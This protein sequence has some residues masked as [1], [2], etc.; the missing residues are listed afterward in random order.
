MATKNQL[1]LLC[2]MFAMYQ[3]MNASEAAPSSP[4]TGDASA[5]AVLK[6][7]DSNA[8]GSGSVPQPVQSIDSGAAATVTPL[9]ASLQPDAAAALAP[10]AKKDGVGS[11]AGPAGGSADSAA[12]KST[13]AT[14]STLAGA[15][16]AAANVARTGLKYGF[17]KNGI[18][19]FGRTAAA[20]ILLADLG[21]I[22][23]GQV[24]LP[25]NVLEN[26]T[27]INTAVSDIT[28]GLLD[29]KIEGEV[30]AKE[31]ADLKKMIDLQGKCKEK[32]MHMGDVARRQGRAFFNKHLK[33]QLASLQRTMAAYSE[34]F[35]K[36]L[37][38]RTDDEDADKEVHDNLATVL[39]KTKHA[40]KKSAK[41]SAA[42][43]S[44]SGAA[45]IALVAAKGNGA[46]ATAA[47]K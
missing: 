46:D 29:K 41:I 23:S 42:I 6:P 44:A 15:S 22:P 12:E 18:F 32:K 47:A 31:Q 34:S 27:L 37:G 30:T 13:A 25:N 7:G 3:S 20:D 19:G 45:A 21:A 4:N 33:Q 36:D 16:T 2:S 11:G 10:A 8:A 9:T 14:A 43:D 40:G 28:A 39:G 17:K 38:S 35:D 5:A 1:F 24:A 26:A